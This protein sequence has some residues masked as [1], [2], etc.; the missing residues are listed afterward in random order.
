MPTGV[1]CECGKG[2]EEKRR[3]GAEN[4][5]AYGCVK[6]ERPPTPPSAGGLEQTE[7][8]L[9]APARGARFAC[10]GCSVCFVSVSVSVFWEGESV[11]VDMHAGAV[12]L[13]VRRVFGACI[14]SGRFLYER[15]E[16]EQGPR[17]EGALR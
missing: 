1:C 13:P 2:G 11:C 10:L 9:Y 16:K 5:S 7:R 12:T 15:G 3:G 4:E 6:E 14:A 8:A 17:E